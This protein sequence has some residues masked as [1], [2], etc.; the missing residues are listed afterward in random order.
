MKKWDWE[1]FSK[2]A[3]KE[4]YDWYKENYNKP[5]TEED[6]VLAMQKIKSFSKGKSECYKPSK[7][8]R[9]YQNVKNKFG[10][11]VG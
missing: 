5:V 11:F 10:F 4:R 2:K 9:V 3:C 8:K 1:K 7:L 6:F